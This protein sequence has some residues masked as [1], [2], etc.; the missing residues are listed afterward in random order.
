M[1]LSGN[2][3]AWIEPSG[4][5]EFIGAF[6]GEGATPDTGRDYPGRAPATR[7]CPS[8]DDARRWVEEEAAA[9]DLPIRW[10]EGFPHK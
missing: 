9:L 4:T 5:G 7:H 2:L 10:L 3:L 1:T 8:V 6:V